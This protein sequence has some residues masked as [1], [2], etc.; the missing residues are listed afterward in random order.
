LLV[1]PIFVREAM[2]APRRVRHYLSRA[3]YGALLF[4]LMWTAWQ[5]MVGFQRVESA[6]DVARFGNFV[7]QVLSVV[8]L[9][10]ALF[11]AP[12]VAGSSI[13]AEKDRR[14]FVLLLVTDLTNWEIVIGK[15]L[16]SLL[17][18]TVLLAAAVPIFTMCLVLGGASPTQVAGVFVITAASA[19]AS[20][21]LGILIASWR[22]K[23]FQTLA[24]TVLILVLYLVGLH[25]LLGDSAPLGLPAGT[26][27]AILSPFSALAAVI[28]PPEAAAASWGRS[29]VAATAWLGLPAGSAP[30]AAFVAAMLLVTAG[31]AGTAVATLRVWNPGGGKPTHAREAIEEIERQ[32]AAEA[33]AQPKAEPRSIW[34]NPVL[35]RE[36]RT[37]AYGRRPLLV[38]LAYFLVFAVILL[39][40][41]L[42]ARDNPQMTQLGVAKTIVP[43]LFLATSLI[44]INVQAVT[45]ITSERDGRALDLLLVT[46]ITPKEFIF[47]K[48]LGVLYNTKEMLALPIAG[49]SVLLARGL[50]DFELWLYLVLGFGVLCTFAITLGLHASLA[51]EQ[52]R[53]AVIN[54]LGTIVFLFL[55]IAFCVYLIRFS[56]RFE[57]QAA[58]FVLFLCGGSVGLYV[59]LAVRNQST[60]LF[61][62]SLACPWLTW[63]AIV[64][65]LQGGDP[66]G[67][68]LATATSYG[69]AVLAMLVPAVSEFDV[70]LGRT[71]TEQG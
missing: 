31:L 22:E 60:A 11:F 6:G 41:F 39:G 47:G 3:S 53:A 15:L 1:G 64:H 32:M 54:S 8:Q 69:F 27:R 18:M 2:T 58:N 21:S 50:L 29:F 67:A 26:W 36:V 35:W 66:L 9:S 63:W 52:T 49:V 14:T 70:A 10:L 44:L 59:S 55:G 25:F 46:D 51:Y 33:Q 61:L 16:A 30:Q 48:I 40:F 24:L 23:T 57:A 4:V 12:I 34:D 62:V 7:F 13:S 45:A 71:V 38:K 42:A 28:N 56:S 37:R 65:L 43:V 19:L 5:H 20:G 68:F 17:Q